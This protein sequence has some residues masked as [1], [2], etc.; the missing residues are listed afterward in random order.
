MPP[1]F[2]AE[3]ARMDTDEVTVV[4]LDPGDPSRPARPWWT[5]GPA[6]ARALQRA[7]L[8]LLVFSDP[9]GEVVRVGAQ[10]SPN[11]IPALE[12]GFNLSAPDPVT[13]T[14][15]DSL[16]FPMPVPPVDAGLVPGSTTF[17]GSGSGSSQA[18]GG[19]GNGGSSLSWSGLTHREE[20]LAGVAAAG[21]I[22]VVIQVP[23][24][25]GGT[26]E[27]AFTL[28]LRVPPS[29]PKVTVAILSAGYEGYFK[30]PD[31]Q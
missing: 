22:Q 28:Y 29:Q 30:V 10:P 14:V 8:G 4:R 13:S 17:G 3:P 24:G 15:A 12:Q 6:L 16:A 1:A 25:A 2:G 11:P 9:A 19:L 20:A 5:R 23:D 31:G 21:G 7:C 18:E 26:V 27:K